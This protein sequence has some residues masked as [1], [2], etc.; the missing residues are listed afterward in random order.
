M[1]EAAELYGMEYSSNAENRMSIGPQL[2]GNHK[3]LIQR[4]STI[5]IRCDCSTLTYMHTPDDL[6]A[7]NFKLFK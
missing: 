7:L 3:Q 4:D 6:E 2:S 5:I 1:L